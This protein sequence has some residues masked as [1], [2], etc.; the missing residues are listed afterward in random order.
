[1]PDGFGEREADEQEIGAL[2]AQRD[3]AE[4]DAHERGQD[5]AGDQRGHERPVEHRQGG[6]G[7]IGADA[8]EC[9]GGEI[10][11]ADQHDETQADSD[12]R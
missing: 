9:R 8:D 10:Q 11:L 1:M 7:R 3:V 6:A 5:A 2:G 12:Q 4:H